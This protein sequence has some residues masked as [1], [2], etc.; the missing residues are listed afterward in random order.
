MTEGYIAFVSLEKVKAL[1][2]EM[3]LGY[4]WRH[5]VKI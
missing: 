5:F 4:F 3:F 2:L 1:V